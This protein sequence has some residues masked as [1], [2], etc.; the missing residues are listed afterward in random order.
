MHM[1]H[2]FTTLNEQH[3]QLQAEM[4]QLCGSPTAGNWTITSHR[5]DGQISNIGEVCSGRDYM[6]LQKSSWL[7]LGRSAPPSH[8]PRSGQNISWR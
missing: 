1:L 2:A 5:D 3:T 7:V 6:N 4:M 8:A